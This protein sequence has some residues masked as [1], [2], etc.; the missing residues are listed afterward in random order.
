MAE[1]VAANVALGG[2]VRA[3][4]AQVGVSQEEL[5][6]RSRIDRKHMGTLERG[7]AQPTLATLD[8]LLDATGMSFAELAA[9][10]EREQVAAAGD[11][12]AG[13]GA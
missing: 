2:V 5:A 8:R 10:V 6:L 3:W 12:G 9:L 11:V 7:E 13:E 1:R 4:R